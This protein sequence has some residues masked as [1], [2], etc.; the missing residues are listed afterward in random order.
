MIRILKQFF[1]RHEFYLKDLKQ[2]EL[3]NTEKRVSWKCHKCNKIFYAHCGLDISQK[4]GAIKQL[5]KEIKGQ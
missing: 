4:Y 5:K 1:C 2:T 3:N